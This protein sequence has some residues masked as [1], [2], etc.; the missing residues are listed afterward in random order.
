M[1]VDPAKQIGEK[2]SQLLDW[3]SVTIESAVL[4]LMFCAIIFLIVKLFEELL[5]TKDFGRVLLFLFGVVISFIFLKTDFFPD[6][7]NMAFR[8][9]SLVFFLF[10]LQTIKRSL[11]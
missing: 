11:K 5:P 7:L 8:S 9:S 4:F 10:F 6:F 1:A 3:V 2:W